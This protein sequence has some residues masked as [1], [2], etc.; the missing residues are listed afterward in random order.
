M[1]QGAEAIVTFEGESVHK[2]RIAKGYRHPAIDARLIA[3]RTRTEARILERLK[4]IV[5]IPRLICVDD[6]NLII[7]RINAEPYAGQ[8]IGRELAT[9]I[10]AMHERGVTHADITPKNVL[11]S[12]QAYLIDFGLATFSDRIEDRAYDL[13]MTRETFS[14]YPGFSEALIEAYRSLLLDTAAFDE[15][16]ARIRERGRNKKKS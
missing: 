3:Q 7:D 4:G 14:A 11:V 5:G 6:D 10:F 15:R 9:I 2:R 12:D 1:I 8:N 13:S 16:I